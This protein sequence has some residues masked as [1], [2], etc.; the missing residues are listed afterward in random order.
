MAPSSPRAD[1]TALHKGGSVLYGMFSAWSGVVGDQEYRHGGRWV[2][3]RP[4][5]LPLHFKKVVQPCMECF[6][7]GV[8]LVVIHLVVALCHSS[9]CVIMLF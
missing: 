3:H 7:L 8:Q 2:H 9:D 5:Q 4:W 1:I 6:P